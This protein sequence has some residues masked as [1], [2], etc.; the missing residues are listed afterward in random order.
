MQIAMYTINSLNFLFISKIIINA[1]ANPNIAPE[2]PADIVK[3]G[4]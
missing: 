3:S 1:P 2:A 4:N